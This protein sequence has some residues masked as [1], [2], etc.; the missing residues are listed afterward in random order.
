VTRG[1]DTKRPRRMGTLVLVAAVLA[2]LALPAS[3]IAVPALDEYALDLPDAKGKVESPQARPVADPGRL[4]PDVVSQL[5]RIPSGEALAA[6]ATAGSLGR[7]NGAQVSNPE[8]AKGLRS[9]VAG[10]QPSMLAALGSAAGDPEAIGL[11]ALILLIAGGMA[12]AKR[13]LPKP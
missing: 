2:A 3:A 7:P 5:R 1:A 13:R 6:I 11:L 4:Q 9:A 10:D 8:A 12:L